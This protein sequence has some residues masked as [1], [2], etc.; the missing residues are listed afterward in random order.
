MNTIK[1]LAAEMLKLRQELNAVRITEDSHWATY[2]ADLLGLKQEL[3]K[4]YSE[5]VEY[6]TVDPLKQN[7]FGK[8]AVDRPPVVST[9]P[10]ENAYDEAADEEEEQKKGPWRWA[11]RKFLPWKDS[12]KGDWAEYGNAKTGQRLAKFLQRPSGHAEGELYLQWCAKVGETAVRTFWRSKGFDAIPEGLNGA[13][14]K[15]ES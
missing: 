4:F 9:H 3:K 10:S 6:V 8:P 15:E 11:R 12:V 7:R 1:E 14:V 5:A 13:F 2:Q